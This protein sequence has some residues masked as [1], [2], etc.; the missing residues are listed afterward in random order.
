MIVLTQMSWL[1]YNILTSQLFANVEFSVFIAI[2]TRMETKKW[3]AWWFWSNANKVFLISW[4]F[5]SQSV[6][7]IALRT[8]AFHNFDVQQPN[9]IGWWA[10]MFQSSFA[11]LW[12]DQLNWSK[13][14]WNG[15][16]FAGSILDGIF[17][18]GNL[19]SWIQMSLEISVNRFMWCPNRRRAIVW[20]NGDPVHWRMCVSR[21]QCVHL[22]TQR[23]GA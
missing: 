13:S 5:V 7:H 22:P 9:G 16:R 6:Y 2:L 17:V 10:A 20:S 14:G 11:S 12:Q 18:K 15:W 4:G 1:H 23:A 8:K 3:R 19:Y 21:P